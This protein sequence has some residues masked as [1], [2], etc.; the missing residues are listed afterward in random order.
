MTLSEEG[1][2]FPRRK[3]VNG[4]SP[5][6][7]SRIAQANSNRSVGETY[8]VNK[9][10]AM[11]FPPRQRRVLNLPGYRAITHAPCGEFTI[12]IP[13]DLSAGR[14]ARGDECIKR[15]GLGQV[16]RSITHE[17]KMVAC[18]QQN[19]CRATR[20]FSPYHEESP[21]PRR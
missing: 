10:E 4:N 15:V 13:D 9:V 11:P 7:R 19:S 8:F 12:Q 17:Q 3:R 14:A 5:T 6:L 18:H 2:Q 1:R 21:F 16:L 20:A